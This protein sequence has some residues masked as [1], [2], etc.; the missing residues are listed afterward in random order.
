MSGKWKFAVAAVAAAAVA[1]LTGAVLAQGSGSAGRGGAPGAASDTARVHL[2]AGN[3]QPVASQA[4]PSA[5]G[6]GGHVGLAFLETKPVTVPAGRS[7]I[8]VGPAPRR[9]RTINGYYFVRGQDRTK[10]ASE[11]DSPAGHRFWK[12]YRNNRTGKA[13]N[14]VAYG[15][16]CLRGARLI[17]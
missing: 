10:I 13:I 16:V 5:T 8:K 9:C 4:A 3:S 6:S 11:G 7:K 1:I 12:F 17:G 2:A 14:G 15:L